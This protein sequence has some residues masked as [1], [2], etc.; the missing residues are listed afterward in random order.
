[1]LRGFHGPAL[2]YDLSVNLNNNIL[3]IMMSY[4]S[5]LIRHKYQGKLLN[6]IVKTKLSSIRLSRSDN[7]NDFGKCLETLSN[8]NSSLNDLTKGSHAREKI[9]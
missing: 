4:L 6:Q 9:S 1:M 7:P 3:N 8:A 2:R 5:F